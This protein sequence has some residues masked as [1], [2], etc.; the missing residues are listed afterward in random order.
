MTVPLVARATWGAQPWRPQRAMYRKDPHAQVAVFVHY[1][2]APPH[3][4][5]G[6]AMAR[7]IESIHLGN[8]WA[9]VGYTAMIGQDGQAFE[10]RGWDLVTA[11]CPGWNTSAWHF[12]VAVG[13]S[14]TPS[15]A[16]LHT[17]AQL[18]AEACQRAGR[19]LAKTW[20]GA[21]YPTECPGNDLRE[22]VRAGM[23]DPI[24]PAPLP[25]PAP[26]GKDPFDMATPREAADALLDTP[27]PGG[28]LGSDGHP[29]TYRYALLRGYHAAQDADAKL[30]QVLDELAEL[31]ARLG[32]VS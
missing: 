4:D 25:R 24:A 23:H 32:S 20:H 31:R 1:H 15:A 29:L 6:V 13:G 12:Y 27:V 7:E 2:G 17:L 21:H 30:Q 8:G 16:A 11:A 18:Y 19:P 22:W 14:L 28:E 5:R 26:S 3:A 9:G 10:G